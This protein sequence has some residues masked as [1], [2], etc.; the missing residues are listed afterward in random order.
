MVLE[1]SKKQKNFNFIVFEGVGGIV[2][3]LV[4]LLERNYTLKQRKQERENKER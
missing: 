4:N 2:S 3:F 1:K